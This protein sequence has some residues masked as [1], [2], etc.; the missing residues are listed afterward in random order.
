MDE[1]Q[2]ELRSKLNFCR[3]LGAKRVIKADKIERD[4]RL[5]V[6][7]LG[8]GMGGSAPDRIGA[9]LPDI[10]ISTSTPGLLSSPL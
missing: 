9:A 3:E 1:K 2:I 8:T 6:I 10:F 7:Q 4:L 5:K